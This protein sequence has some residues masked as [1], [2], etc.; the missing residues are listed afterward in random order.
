MKLRGISRVDDARQHSWYVRVYHNNKVY[1]ATIRDGNHRGKR[2]AL[3]IAI[4][5]K[6]Q[7]E[8]WLGAVPYAIR[9]PFRLDGKALPGNTTG[10]NGVC[11][12]FERAKVS[13]KKVPC[14]SVNYCLKGVK[15]TRR[16]YIH[17]YRSRKLALQAAVAFRKEKEREMLREWEKS[18]RS[19]TRSRGRTKKA[20]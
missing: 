14:Y 15:H 4:K 9:P 5:Y 2:N 8:R 18:L 20:T 19:L 16:F 7:L 11:E 17:R 6:E 13:G 3:R 10:V 1:S 12:T